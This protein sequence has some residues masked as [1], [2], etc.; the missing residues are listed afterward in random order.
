MFPTKT[1]AKFWASRKAAPIL[2]ALG[3]FP[4]AKIDEVVNSHSGSILGTDG[5]RAA[6][7]L[8]SL[9]V[10]VRRCNGNLEEYLRRIHAEP[11]TVIAPTKRKAFALRWLNR[12]QETAS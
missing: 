10:S 4:D 6:E 8:V 2:R 7:T 9:L 12:L 5:E 1:D 11:G 3:H